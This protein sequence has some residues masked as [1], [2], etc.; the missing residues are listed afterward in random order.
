MKGVWLFIIGMLSTLFLTAIIVLYTHIASLPDLHP[1]HTVV[2][3]EEYRS[4]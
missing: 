2:L 1:W 4:D 3:E